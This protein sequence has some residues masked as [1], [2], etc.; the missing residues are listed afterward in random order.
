MS[1]PHLKTSRLVLSPPLIHDNM[2][3]T[4]HLRWLKN[5]QVLQ[6]SENRHFEHCRQSQLEYL[7]SFN[8]E[9]NHF[10]EIQ[11]LGKPLGSITAYL[12]TPNRTAN[13]GIMIG[14]PDCWGRNYASEA[15]EVVCKFLF[16]DKTRKIEAACMASNIPMIRVLENNKFSY[17]ATIGQH[18]LLDGKPE[19]KVCYG[20]FK[21]AK[22][23]PLA[24]RNGRVADSSGVLGEAS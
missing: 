17:E 22:I 6:F 18:F 15:W 24:G 13:L 1:T 7:R 10:W 12:N 8:G 19:D 20:K 2:D 11:T 21:K 16:S 23:I 4:H 5:K 9:T 3:V 14:E